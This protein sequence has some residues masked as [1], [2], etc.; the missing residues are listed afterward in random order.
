M[1][2]Q[3]A[4]HWE[5]STLWIDQLGNHCRFLACVK[6]HKDDSRQITREGATNVIRETKIRLEMF[7]IKEKIDWIKTMAHNTDPPGNAE[8]NVVITLLHRI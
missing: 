2:F 7:R 8:Q 5:L 4:K 3:H 6:E 1:C